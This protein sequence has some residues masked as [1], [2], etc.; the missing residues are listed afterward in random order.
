MIKKLIRSLYVIW[1]KCLV[2]SR[3]ICHRIA[4]CHVLDRLGWNFWNYLINVLAMRGLGVGE[5]AI[6]FLFYI[7]IHLNL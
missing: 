1:D 7:I 5:E 4:C 2:L 3:G 6:K